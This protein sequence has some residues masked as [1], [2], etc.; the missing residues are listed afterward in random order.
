[1]DTM[2]QDITEKTRAVRDHKNRDKQ[3]ESEDRQLERNASTNEAQI[4][5]LD[6]RLGVGMGA[7]KERKRL[8]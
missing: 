4:R 1:M 6:N 7:A 8:M 2:K 3:A 5:E